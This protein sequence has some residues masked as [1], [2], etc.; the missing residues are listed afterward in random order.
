MEK[1]H[2]QLIQACEYYA[3]LDKYDNAI[4]ML[5]NKSIVLWNDYDRAKKKEFRAKPGMLLIIFTG[6]FLFVLTLIVSMVKAYRPTFELYEEPFDE[7]IIAVGMAI[8]MLVMM[9]TV[10]AVLIY[11]LGYCRART[12]KIQAKAE[13]EW[14]AKNGDALLQYQESIDRLENER[15]NF[16]KK[17]IRVLY[18]LPDIYRTRLATAYMERTVRTGRADSLKE[19]MNLYEEQL[20]RWR[21]EE[22][23]R[24]LLQQKEMQT[25]MIQDQLTSI[26]HEQRRVTNSLQNIEALEF[27]NTFCR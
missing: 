23:G 18:F 4:Q 8:G 9:L 13:E 26:L 6:V 24:Q 21:L 15:N 12:R 10:G 16:E 19:A 5:N 1:L 7:L 14:I 22:Q 25:A 20:H 3:M 2:D 17:H 11:R 27:Y